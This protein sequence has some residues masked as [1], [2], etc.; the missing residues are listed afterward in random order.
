MSESQEKENAK[1]ALIAA[2]KF[3]RFFSCGSGHAVLHHE[4][5][6]ESR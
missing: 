3:A 1:Q 4:H 6:S 2:M 5:L